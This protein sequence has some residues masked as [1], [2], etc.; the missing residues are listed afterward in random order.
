MK[1]RNLLLF[2]AL[3]I[4]YSL[5][6]RAF[7]QSVLDNYIRLGLDSNLALKQQSFDLEKAKLDLERA[8]ALFYPQIGFNAQY[9]LANGGR[10]IDVPLGDLL[11]N[12]YSSLNQLTSSAKFPQVKN[13]SIQLL[14]N[15]FQETKVEV[16][17]PLYNPSL[18]YN[19]K[20]KE[21][22]INTQQQQVNLY[23][24]ELVFNIKQAYYQY[25]QAS[26]AVEIYNNALATV[27]E[28]LRF[29]EKLVK[30]QAATK[31]AVLKAKAEV[32]KVQTS[33]VD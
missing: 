31:E 25:L 28:S 17:M 6:Q 24:R 27:N 15:D 11:N 2:I 3:L 13:Q 1:K 19:K 14:P 18:G 20:M 26:K 12:V 16:S 4:L 33:L 22:L 7:G 8:K 5:W 30:N 21:E 10:T 23:K 32:S 29:N 9:T